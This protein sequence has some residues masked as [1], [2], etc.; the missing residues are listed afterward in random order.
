[1]SD[2]GEGKLVKKCPFLGEKWCIGE[3]CAIYMEIVQQRVVLGVS[4]M[5]KVGSCSLPALAMIMSNRPQPQQPV[6][7]INFP[8]IGK[9]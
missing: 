1:M 4:Q 9:G 7:K 3:D 2:N 8:N 5:V 6:Q